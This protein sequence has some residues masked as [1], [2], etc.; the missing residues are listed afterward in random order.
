M[1]PAPARQPL[2]A[3]D[4][5]DLR[6][7]SLY[8]DREL[9]LPSSTIACSSRRRTRFDPL[10][11]S[12]FLC[13]SSTNLDEFFEIRV[14]GLMQKAEL[15]STPAWMPTRCSRSEVLTRDSASV[16]T[17]SCDEQYRVL[18]ESC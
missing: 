15:G 16:P 14:A 17:S 1:T 2:H 3:V 9:S 4:E 18:N 10:S 8:I 7:P 5:I 13:I 11:A 6:D 12:R